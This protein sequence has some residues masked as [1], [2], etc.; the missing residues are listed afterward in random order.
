MSLQKVNAALVQAY[1]AM[2]LG[3]PTG[4]E[5][6]DFT[7]PA[8]G[9]W[10]A[11]FNIPAERSPATL[12]DTGQD[13]QTG[14]FQIDFHVPENT[15]TKQ[16]LDWADQTVAAFKAGRGLLY[17]GQAVRIR[18]TQPSPIMKAEDGATFVISL[19]IYWNAWINR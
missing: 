9:N 18:R 2:A 5:T 1:Q 16:L 17:N 8:S 4:Y 11:V 19:S 12:G 13:L 14:V 15:G 3:L 10:A 7:P 6:K